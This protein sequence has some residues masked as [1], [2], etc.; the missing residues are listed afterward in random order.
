MGIITLTTD[1]G[2]KDSYVS[3]IKGAIFSQI[4]DVNIVDISH[5]IEPFNI[6]Q[7][8]YIVKS[9]YNDFPSGTVHL[10]G[11]DSELTSNNEHLAIKYENHFFLGADNGIFSILFNKKLPDEIVQLNI[12]QKTN[13]LTFPS[14]DI[15]TIAACHII[16]GGT[17]EI[18]GKKI[19]EFNEKRTELKPVIEKNTI[20]GTIIY[21]DNYGN[22]VSNINKETFEKTQKNRE[23]RIL[24]GRENEIISK[25]SN[26]FKEVPIAEKLALFNNNNLL[27]ISINQGRATNLL[28]LKFHDTIRIEFL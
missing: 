25:I 3:S 10:I 7:A 1:L 27:Q 22:V 28:G 6:H 12:N 23:F 11:V 16:R 21:I 9:C 13:S 18:I 19:Y 8:A 2:T 5:S 4:T 26:K 17:L 24:F 14:K 20:R 15:L